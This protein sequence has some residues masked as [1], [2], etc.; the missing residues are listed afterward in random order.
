MSKRLWL[1]ATDG[2][3]T[4]H[5]EHRCVAAHARADRP[6]LRRTIH[7]HLPPNAPTFF[8]HDRA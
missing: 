1:K 4:L 8:A 2:M 7:D 5:D 3:V 6:G